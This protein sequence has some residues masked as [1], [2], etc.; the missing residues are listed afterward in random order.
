VSLKGHHTINHIILA[1]L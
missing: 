1:V